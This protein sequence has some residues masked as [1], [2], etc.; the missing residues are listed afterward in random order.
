MV[1]EGVHN[2]QHVTTI[3]TAEGRAQHEALFHILSHLSAN[4][5]TKHLLTTMKQKP[6]LHSHV[7]DKPRQARPFPVSNP[8][9]FTF[10]SYVS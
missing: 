6:K 7:R 5:Q 4:K 1:A 2:L 8:I 10:I 9:T 3:V